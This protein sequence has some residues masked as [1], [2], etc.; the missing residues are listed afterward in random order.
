MLTPKSRRRSYRAL[1]VVTGAGSG[2]GRA[3]AVELGRRGGHVI[4]ADIDLESA[5]QTVGLVHETGG[6]AIAVACDVSDRHEVDR[7]AGFVRNTFQEPV[8]LVVNNAGVG[9]G[10]QRIGELDPSEWERGIGVNLWGPIYGC[11]AFVPTLRA[12]GSGGI[13]NVAS[14]ASYAASPLMAPYCVSKAGVLALSEVLAAELAG[15]GVVVTA[16][17]PTLVKTNIAASAKIDESV[18]S[19]LGT[20][21]D[22]VGFSADR[23]ARITLDAHDAGQLYVMPQLDAKLFWA[24][25]RHAP[26]SYLLGMKAM[27]TVAGWLLDENVDTT[28]ASTEREAA[29]AS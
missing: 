8:S 13:I 29:T 3:F 28:P 14:A 17:C 11:E 16:L 6:D 23:V 24:A 10:G 20:V 9:A 12:A 27:N 2:I 18:S 19:A 15:S 4:C 21:M 1:A 7:L 5:Q 25:K 22:L 26:R